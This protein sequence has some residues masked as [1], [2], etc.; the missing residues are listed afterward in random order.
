M[1]TALKEY[2]LTADGNDGIPIEHDIFFQQT[3]LWGDYRC[4]DPV[5]W[6]DRGPEAGPERILRG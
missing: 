4:L 5:G 1:P 3:G 6:I 2:F